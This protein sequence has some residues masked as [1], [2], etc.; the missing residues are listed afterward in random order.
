MAL[1][2]SRK[3]GVKTPEVGK[4]AT[5]PPFA[6]LLLTLVGLSTTPVQSQAT[7]DR[8]F[9]AGEPLNLSANAHRPVSL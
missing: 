6:L 2:L 1:G 5:F 4:G 7:S 8:P 9:V 3:R